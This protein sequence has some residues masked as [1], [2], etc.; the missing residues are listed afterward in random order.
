MPVVGVMR[1]F[2]HQNFPE[3]RPR[4]TVAGAHRS[5]GC[6]QQLHGL[7]VQLPQR[8]SFF[9]SSFIAFLL[10]ARSERIAI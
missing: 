7:Q 8:Q 1:M 4:K 10:V 6:D 5:S 9:S 3:V 2:G